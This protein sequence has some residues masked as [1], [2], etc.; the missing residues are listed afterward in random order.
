MLLTSLLVT[1]PLTPP[2]GH[3]FAVIPRR[4][5]KSFLLGAVRTQLHK[6]SGV[7]DPS[8][9]VFASLAS[10]GQHRQQ[11][12]HDVIRGG[13]RESILGRGE[14]DL[15]GET[16]FEGEGWKKDIVRRKGGGKDLRG[17]GWQGKGKG[18][19]DLGGSK[20]NRSWG[21]RRILEGKRWQKIL[22]RKREKIS[23][24]KRP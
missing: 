11:D 10:P 19:K 2:Q 17:E 3:G 12:A 9:F 14:K 8:G 15:C 24:G 23:G 4:S 21:E 22:G 7:F 6:N 5:T 16:I 13:R 1:P 20:E 18:G